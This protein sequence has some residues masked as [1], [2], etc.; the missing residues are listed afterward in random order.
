MVS[1]IVSIV[2]LN[3]FSE[4]LNIF[5]SRYKVHQYNFVSG[6]LQLSDLCAMAPPTRRCGH[7][8]LL[9]QSRASEYRLARIAAHVRVPSGDEGCNLFRA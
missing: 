9:P 3:E 4:K 2:D 6:F 1:D 8:T 7:K 5:A